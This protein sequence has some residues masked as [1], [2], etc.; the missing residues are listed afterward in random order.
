MSGNDRKEGFPEKKQEKM[1]ESRD[2]KKGRDAKGWVERKEVAG[3]RGEENE[4]STEG[5]K[6]E[7]EKWGLK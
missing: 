2:D 7:E 1:S 4:R 3:K 6:E 5:R